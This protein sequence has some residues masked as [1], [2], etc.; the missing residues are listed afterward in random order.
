MK[1]K[2]GFTL[3]ELAI[4]V[5][6]IAVMITATMTLTQMTF[7][8]NYNQRLTCFYQNECQNIINCFQTATFTMN[9]DKLDCSGFEEKL[10]FLYGLENNTTFNY[11]T[12]QLLIEYENQSVYEIE[13]DQYF[14]YTDG[15]VNYLLVCTLDYDEDNV[16]LS[17]EVVNTL[18]NDSVIYKIDSVATKEVL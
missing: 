4:T 8:A 10:D 13:Y 14:K 3:A 12:H 7:T 18:D 1:N 11:R 5:A 9:G 16:T 15:T 6:V 17:L 2:R